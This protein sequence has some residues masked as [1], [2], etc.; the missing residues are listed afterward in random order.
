MIKE[1]N[2]QLFLPIQFGGIRTINI[3]KRYGL[4]QKTYDKI[5][6]ITK[7]GIMIRAGP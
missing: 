7:G 4:L 6:Q 1:K 3:H 2:K 5:E